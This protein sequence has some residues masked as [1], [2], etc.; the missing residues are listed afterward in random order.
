MTSI[1]KVV[2]IDTLN[3]L[4]DKYKDTHHKT[5]KMKPINVKLSIYIDFDVDIIIKIPNLKLVIMYKYRNIR[6]FLQGPTCQIG[7]KKILLL[8]NLKILHRGHK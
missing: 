8:A 4:V 7:Q 5:S 3:G 1:S 6:T 2:K